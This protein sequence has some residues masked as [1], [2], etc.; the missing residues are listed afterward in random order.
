M[1]R[2]PGTLVPLEVA[3]LEAALELREGGKGE[4]HGYAIATR[5]AEEGSARKLAAYGTLYRAL[6]R[7]QKQEL[8][9]SQWEDPAIAEAASRPRRRLYRVTGAGESALARA[10]HVARTASKG[11]GGRLE[12]GL[13]ST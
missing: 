11:V 13:A 3:I 10:R 5:I 4:F 12:E 1:R 9:E 6:G 2:K 8:L 7:L